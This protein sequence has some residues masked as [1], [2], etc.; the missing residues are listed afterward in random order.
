MLHWKL[1][2]THGLF[3]IPVIFFIRK[4]ATFVKKLDKRLI[5]TIVI[6]VKFHSSIKNYTGEIVADPRKSGKRLR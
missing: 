2:M 6:V 5:S 1:M 3:E 4:F